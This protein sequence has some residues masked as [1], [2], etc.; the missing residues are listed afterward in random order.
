MVVSAVICVLGG[1]GLHHDEIRRGGGIKDLDQCCTDAVAGQR[2]EI[3][4]DH[5]SLCLTLGVTR[6]DGDIKDSVGSEQCDGGLDGGQGGFTH[7]SDALIAAGEITEV[8]HT[9]TV[10][11]LDVIGHLMVGVVDQGI[12]LRAALLAECFG[13]GGEGLLLDIEGVDVS[14]LADGFGEKG[15]IMAVTHGEVNGGV[16]L[17]KVGEDE[18]LMEIE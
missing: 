1:L 10:G 6:V 16:T 11:F 2:G 3:I 18:L 14:V 7:G 9:R 5:L 4:A 15:G 12:I 13:G 8:E 17:A